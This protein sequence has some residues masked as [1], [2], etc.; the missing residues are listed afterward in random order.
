MPASPFTS[1]VILIAPRVATH[2]EYSR[3]IVHPLSTRTGVENPLIRAATSS[4]LLTTR[5][6]AA[7]KGA[8]PHPYY[9]RKLL[10]QRL[11]DQR[12]REA[13]IK[14][15]ATIGISKGLDEASGG[16][17]RALYLNDTRTVSKNNPNYIVGILFTM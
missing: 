13:R 14:P 2:V 1:T 15:T 11:L 16:R 7:K 4:V 17:K 9:G 10:T 5:S 12:E 3:R 8:T 6:R